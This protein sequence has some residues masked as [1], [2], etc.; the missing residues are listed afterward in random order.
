M[1]SGLLSSA[2]ASFP[3]LICASESGFVA[4]ICWLKLL[5][6][7]LR[8]RKPAGGPELLAQILE[9]VRGDLGVRTLLR[10]QIDITDEARRLLIKKGG[11][12]SIDFIRPTG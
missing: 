10:M 6:R 3:A 4:R 8:Q 7:S 1:Q 5:G 11:T 12:M 2:G 9:R